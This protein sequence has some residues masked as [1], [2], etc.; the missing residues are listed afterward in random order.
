MTN[1]IPLLHIEPDAQ[2]AEFLQ[3]NLEQAG[4]AVTTVQSGKEGLIFAWR[5]QPKIIVTELDLPDID[6]FEMVEKLRRDRR[7]ERTTI[8]GL[9]LLKDPSS[10]V[11]AKEAGVDRFFVKQPEAINSLVDYLNE[12]M[13][14][15]STSGGRQQFAGEGKVT[16]LL[17]IKGG[18][19]TTSL[20]VNIAHDL[21]L[22]LDKR[23]ILA[24]DFDFPMGSMAFISGVQSRLTLDQILVQEPQA[25]GSMQ[26]EQELTAPKAWA[27][28]VLPGFKRPDLMQD[29]GSSNIPAMLQVLRKQYEHM[30]IDLGRDL[31]HANQAVLGQSDLIL[32]VLHPD[33]ECVNRTKTISQYLRNLGMAAEKIHFIT[34]RPMPTESLTGRSTE[35][36]LGHPVL[37]AVPH[38]GDQFTLAN[39]LHAPIA[40]RFP[41][42]RGNLAIQEIAKYIAGEKIADKADIRLDMRQ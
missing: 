6:G 18:V 41:D 16:S 25:L 4:F 5:D 35:D 21:G 30:V 8:V 42:S 32:L 20:A 12:E 24:I 2:T 17:G 3:H 1:A 23:R 15:Q 7:T 10:A 9:T 37:S 29:W 11:Q 14:S 40:L 38:M 28:A 13:R 22:I 26:L 36:A 27:C 33:E 39:S 19:G 31:G 34:N